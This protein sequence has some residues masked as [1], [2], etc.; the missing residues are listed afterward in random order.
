MHILPY[1]P[2]LVKR[3]SCCL[4]TKMLKIRM[5]LILDGFDQSPFVDI[6]LDGIG[7]LVAQTSQLLSLA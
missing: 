6:V 1:E 7:V 3:D 5:P 2:K 4:P